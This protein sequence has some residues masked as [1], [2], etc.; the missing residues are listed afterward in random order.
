MKNLKKSMSDVLA[1]ICLISAKSACSAT[2][3]FGAYQ[4]KEPANLK[5]RIAKIEKK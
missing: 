2:S 3:M 4:A 1:K 5:E